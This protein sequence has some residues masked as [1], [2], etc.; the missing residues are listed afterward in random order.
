MNTNPTHSCTKMEPINQTNEV[1]E[2]HAN[3][4]FN[5][6]CAQFVDNGKIVK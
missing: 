6:H 5:F 1:P 2:L 4:H 3:T